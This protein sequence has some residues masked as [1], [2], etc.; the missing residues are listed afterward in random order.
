MQ[1]S[2]GWT[3]CNV[4]AMDGRQYARV[5]AATGIIA[6]ALA[7][8]TIWPAQVAVKPGD[9][10]ALLGVASEMAT[11]TSATQV[12]A[13]DTIGTT[14]VTAPFCRV[15]GVARP[16][17]DSLINFEVWL[18]AASAWSG[19][20]KTDGTGGYAGATPVAR[21]A[22]DLAA[23]FVVAG[24]DMGHAGGESAD[25]TMGHRARSRTG[26]TARTIS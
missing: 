5:A 22:A 25:W 7:G 9:C 3:T 14:K 18:P 16:S 2:S 11:I 4:R 12:A 1:R 13:A 6:I 20:L 23:G 26:D 15:Q 21:M 8:C 19:R 10:S 24:S 17:T